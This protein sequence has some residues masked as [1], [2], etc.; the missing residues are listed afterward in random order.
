MAKRIALVSC[1]AAKL[2]TKALAKDLYISPLFRAKRAY[3]ELTCDA[4]YILS[5]KHGLLRPNEEI[6]PYDLSLAE[7][8]QEERRT[9]GA[10]VNY[11]LGVLL[12][13]GSRVVLLAGALY[14]EHVAPFLEANKFFVRSPLAKLAIG[15][16]LHWLQNRTRKPIDLDIEH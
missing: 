14:C 13:P 5:A 12:P 3:A 2:S 15:K 9:W 1:V 6:E 16:Q 11:D 7:L 8:T 4:W 10:T